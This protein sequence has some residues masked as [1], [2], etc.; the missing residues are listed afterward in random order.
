MIH[1]VTGVMIVGP[2]IKPRRKRN[3]AYLSRVWSNV[4]PNLV[5]KSAARATAP[6]NMS[7]TT[8]RS[9]RIKPTMRSPRKKKYAVMRA[10]KTVSPV[11]MLGVM[12]VFASTR[13]T[14]IMTF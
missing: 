14:G 12:P 8:V 13:P 3:S 6:S 5:P 4:A 9:I 2:I 11:I 10:T 1:H 7:I